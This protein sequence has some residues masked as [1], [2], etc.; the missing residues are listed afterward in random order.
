MT[1]ERDHGGVLRPLSDID[2]ILIHC[3]DT[4]NGYDRYGA[5]EINAWHLERGFA[6][7]GYHW[8][9]RCSGKLSGHTIRKISSCHRLG[10]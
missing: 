6:G 4:P 3:A 8:V 2:A 1:V 9:V 7:I 10:Q 5:K